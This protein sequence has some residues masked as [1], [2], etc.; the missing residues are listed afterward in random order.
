[1]W[2]AALPGAVEVALRDWV[3][4]SEQ[5][6]LSAQVPDTHAHTAQAGI[7]GVYTA[8]GPIFTRTCVRTVGTR[9]SNSTTKHGSAILAP[10]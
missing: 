8:L 6:E 4:L 1:M 7:D 9:V 2:I 5:P 3:A 10:S